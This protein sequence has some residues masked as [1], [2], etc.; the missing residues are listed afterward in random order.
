MSESTENITAAAALGRIAEIQQFGL[1]QDYSHLTAIKGVQILNDA[2]KKATGIDLLKPGKHLTFDEI[3]KYE[4]FLEDFVE[5]NL[6]IK[7][8]DSFL[9]EEIGLQEKTEDFSLEFFKNFIF[10]KDISRAVKMNFKAIGM[11]IPSILPILRTPIRVQRC[12]GIGGREEF[13]TLSKF[14]HK[15]RTIYAVFHLGKGPIG[16]TDIIS[17][18]SALLKERDKNP[19]VGDAN[20]INTVTCFFFHESSAH[21]Q[22]PINLFF[23]GILKYAQT[24]T[25]GLETKKFFHT[26]YSSQLLID[27]GDNIEI[28]QQ[29]LGVRGAISG[30]ASMRK[31]KTGYEYENLYFLY[32]ERQVQDYTDFKFQ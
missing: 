25:I 11:A 29:T 4:G 9:A 2:A 27:K 32:A 10:S 12:L 21:H 16:H 8:S 31:T 23:K 14:F 20:L 15:S 24:V 30:H 17:S 6:T 28:L 7:V 5:K 22:S 1:Q 13:L 26:G 3:D 18:F 19:P